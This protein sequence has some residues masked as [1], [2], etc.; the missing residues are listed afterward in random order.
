MVPE[1][2][3]GIRTDGDAGVLEH[4]G[5][6]RGVIDSKATVGGNVAVP[7]TRACLGEVDDGICRDDEWTVRA[8][9]T[10]DH[11]GC[12]SARQEREG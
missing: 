8:T 12:E 1:S 6:F 9:G 3:R 4:H 10:R 7:R 11:N 2:D 5:P